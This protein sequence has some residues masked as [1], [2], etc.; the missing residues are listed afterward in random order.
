MASRQATA[1][2]DPMN[3]WKFGPGRLMM[4]SGVSYWLSEMP[5]VRDEVW[6][7]VLRH[8]RGDWGDVSEGDRAENERALDAGDRLMSVYAATDGTR[9]WIITEWDRSVTTVLFPEEY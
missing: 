1:H 6:R 4:T 8:I 3:G 7:M 9:V 5:Q 2:V